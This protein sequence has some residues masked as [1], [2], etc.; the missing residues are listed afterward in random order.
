MTAGTICATTIKPKN[1]RNNQTNIL[2]ILLSPLNRKVATGMP[3][4]MKNYTAR[5]WIEENEDGKSYLWK[6]TMWIGEIIKEELI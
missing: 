6:G 1:P 2:S 3:K 5:Y 4:T